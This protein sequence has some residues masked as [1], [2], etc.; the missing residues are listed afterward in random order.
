[1][2]QS[3]S[4]PMVFVGINLPLDLMERIKARARRK[5][6]DICRHVPYVEVLREVLAREF[7]PEA[8]AGQQQPDQP[9]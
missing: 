5:A 3:K 6:V 7:P 9:Q 2:Q 8:Q 1:M 4:Q